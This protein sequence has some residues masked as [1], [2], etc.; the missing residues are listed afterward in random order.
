MKEY[1]HELIHL[2]AELQKLLDQVG[3]VLDRMVLDEENQQGKTGR[4]N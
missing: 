4:A 1:T 3:R 2:L